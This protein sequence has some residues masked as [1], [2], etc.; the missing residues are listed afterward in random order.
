MA[1]PARFKYCYSTHLGKTGKKSL[2]NLRTPKQ[3][4]CKILNCKA[5]ET[6][7]IPR[8]LKYVFQLGYPS[9][10][11]ATEAHRKAQTQ[12]RHC[13]PAGRQPAA[14]RTQRPGTCWVHH[15]QMRYLCG[16]RRQEKHPLKCPAAGKSARPRTG[17]VLNWDFHPQNEP[18][19]K[20]TERGRERMR[21]WRAGTRAG[22]TKPN[23]ALVK[24]HLIPNHGQNLLP[25]LPGG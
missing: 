2:S 8:E 17:N 23:P 19:S 1:N 4:N 18:P 25:S 15:P 21:R 11:T 6:H 13:E 22:S 20:L 14:R 24:L 5:K 9:P 7:L 16:A 3:R 10:R 12:Y